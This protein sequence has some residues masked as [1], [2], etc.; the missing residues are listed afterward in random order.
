MKLRYL[1]IAILAAMPR[2][3]NASTPDNIVGD[4]LLTHISQDDE[5]HTHMCGAMT[6]TKDNTDF[7]LRDDERHAEIRLINNKWNL[8]S[9]IEGIVSIKSGKYQRDFKAFGSDSTM[10]D[11]DIAE[12]DLKELV[13]VLSSAR[14]ASMTFGKNKTQN[15]PISGSAEILNGFKDCVRHIGNMDLGDPVGQTNSPF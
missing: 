7:L 6:V 5:I 14:S 2:I 3:A 13:A 9:K 4:W 10:L 11:I 1:A 15:I 8:P 12:A